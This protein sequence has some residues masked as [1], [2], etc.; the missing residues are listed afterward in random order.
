[1][2][3]VSIG[4][5][6]SL[7]AHQGGVVLRHQAEAL[8]IDGGRLE[9]RVKTGEWQRVAEGAYRVF[10][11]SDDLDFLRSAVAILPGAVVSHGSAALMLDLTDRPPRRPQVTVHASTTSRCPNVDVRRSRNL[12]AEHTEERNGLPVTSPARTLVDLAVDLR[13]DRWITVA[14]A[15]IA[16]RRVSSEELAEVASVVCGQG[17][18]GSG[19]IREFLDDPLAGSSP[20]ERK[21]V[22]L[23][24][25]ARLPV[26]EREYPLPWDPRRRF[27]LAYPEQRVA[28][29]LDGRRWHDT[30]EAFESD[31]RRDREAVRHGWVVLR[32][33]WEDIVRR[34]HEFVREIAAV[35]DS[36][37][38][39]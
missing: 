7:A 25:E 32:F 3:G 38:V 33:T 1:M 22:R 4:P 26:P 10:P 23:I 6:L 19:T 13:P 27:D 31:R 34:P 18:R 29:E 5:L 12:L 16:R 9:R 20:L 37:S 24:V 2:G 35:L 15:A 28:I 39:R 11:A 17:R 14:D 30:R 36:R 8:G 21:A